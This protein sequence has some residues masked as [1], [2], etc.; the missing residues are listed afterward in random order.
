MNQH[1]R[2][3]RANA[4]TRFSVIITF[5]NQRHFVKNAVDSALSLRNP[6]ME[7][8][9]VDD[10]S[11]DGSP[12][13]LRQYGDSIRAVCLETNQGA[14]A[15]RNHGASLAVGEYLVFLDGDDVFLPWALDVYERVVQEKR[16]AFMLASMRWFE[17]ELPA[18]PAEEVPHE[19]T[20]V[21]YEDYL[22]RDRGF[23]HS[24]SCMVIARQTFEDVRGWPVGFFP[25]EDFELALRLGVSGRTIQILAPP[26]TLHRSHANNT[27]RN[28]AGCII[29]VNN[30]LRK[31]RLGYHP[32]G[33]RRGLERYALM[34]GVVFHWTRR[35][36]KSGLY[37][38]AVKLLA[39]GAPM[40]LAAF[41][42]WL[43]ITLGGREP[44]EV[45]KL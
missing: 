32:G 24:A 16:P 15:A 33:A 44:C 35:A 29:G 42:R 19:I 3:E 39:L 4:L 9:A 10:A 11:T 8:I 45:L 37:W 17:G 2:A 22:R 6:G 38:R 20:V 41:V 14:C 21:D 5:Y 34:G 28:V 25:L 23:G 13:I 12:E 7:I 31:E 30:L 36:L 40:I 26:T 43:E 1:G 27:V 18:V